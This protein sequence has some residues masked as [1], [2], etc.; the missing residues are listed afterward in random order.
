MSRNQTLDRAVAV[1]VEAM[2]RRT[3]LS[4]SA[5]LGAGGTLTVTGT[6]AADIIG[7][8]VDEDGSVAV[9][10]N[11]ANK[12]FVA[13]TVKTI[14]IN[15]GGG[16]DSIAVDISDE[17]INQIPETINAGD[18]NDTVT[19]DSVVQIGPT[20]V[21][22]CGAGNDSVTLN[23]DGDSTVNGGDGNDTLEASANFNEDVC[24]MFGDNGNDTLH[25]VSAGAG[26]NLLAIMSGGNGNDTFRNDD[27]DNRINA[28][29]GPGIDTIQLGE[30]SSGIIA[31]DGVDHGSNTIAHAD[32]ENV[33]GSPFGDVDII[34]NALNNLIDVG[35]DSAVTVLGGGGNDT[36]TA[37]G[38]TTYLDG[39]SGNDVITCDSTQPGTTL[40][41]GDGNDTLIGG[42]APDKLFGGNGNDRLV[43]NAGSDTM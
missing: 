29:G 24:H 23:Y 38:D 28:T 12:Q 18:G 10:V 31:L 25:S 6:G 17:N 5:I 3:L 43:G 14:V 35:S 41:G 26:G 7:L 2:E 32:V 19:I 27:I 34:G 30:G 11:G 33:V 21:V 9:T 39:G 15:S 37:S 1:V 42:D 8:E 13:N 4:G 36:I 40:I 22:N 16:A 20:V